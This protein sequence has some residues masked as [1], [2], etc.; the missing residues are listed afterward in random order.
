MAALEAQIRAIEGV[1]LYDPVRALEMCLVP[2]VVVLKKFRVPEF[3][4]YTGTQCPITH[5]KSYCN[6]MAEAVHDEKLLMH[7]FQDSLNGAALSWYMRLDNTKIHKWKDLV[8][9]FVK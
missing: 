8:D 6:K 2:N 5:L 7:F 1:D 4:K 3:I 9:A